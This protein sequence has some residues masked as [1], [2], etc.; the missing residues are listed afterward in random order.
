MFPLTNCRQSIWLEVSVHLTLKIFKI[1]IMRRNEN[2]HLWTAI[3]LLL[4]T[5]PTIDRKFEYKSSVY[6]VHTYIHT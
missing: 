2:Y 5:I 6:L 3:A 4:H 1:L